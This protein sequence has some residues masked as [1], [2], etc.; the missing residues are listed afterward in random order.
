MTPE[1]K[2]KV[3]GDFKP[4][5]HEAEAEQRWGD[6]PE[7]QESKRRTKSYRKQDWEAI[8]AEAAAIYGDLARLMTAGVAPASTQ[9]MDAAERHRAHVTRW[10]YPCSP[11]VHRGLGELY[12]ADPR[13][14][15]GIDQHGDGLA[16]Y[17]GQ[18]FAA[19]AERQA[20]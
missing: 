6:T 15:A 11:Q 4:E 14:T 19:N 16:A 18:A 5:A 2:L 20:H 8:K 12:V 9:A 13:F 3:F 10:F 1:E 17:C 7:H